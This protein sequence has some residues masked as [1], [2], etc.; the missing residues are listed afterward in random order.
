MNAQPGSA[1]VIE[2]ERV[3]GETRHPA[4]Q[5]MLLVLCGLVSRDRRF[6]RAGDGLCGAEC[7]RRMARLE[8]GA[9]PR[10]QREPVRHAARGLRACRCWPTASEDVRY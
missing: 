6:R 1:N 4:F 7:D 9:R 8:G 5:L 2:V 10:V 3:L